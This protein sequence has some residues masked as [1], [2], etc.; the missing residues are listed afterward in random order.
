MAPEQKLHVALR[1]YHTARQLKEAALRRD[2]PDWTEEEIMKK[3]GKFSSMP[4]LRL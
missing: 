2:H 1:L 3:C 4:E